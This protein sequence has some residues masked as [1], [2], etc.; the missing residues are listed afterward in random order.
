MTDRA[1]EWRDF[2]GSQPYPF[3]LTMVEYRNDTDAEVSFLSALLGQAPDPVL[4]IAC[5]RGR[6]AAR[7]AANGRD[8]VGVDYGQL[9]CRFAAD[10]Q[11]SIRVVSG[12]AAQLPFRDEVFGA[13]FCVYSSIGYEPQH[14]LSIFREA[15]R[16]LVP[17]GLFI[18]DVANSQ[19]VPRTRR[20]EIERVP[21]GLALVSTRFDKSSKELVRTYRVISRALVRRYRLRMTVYSSQ[22][23]I[24]MCQRN[25]LDV[26]KGVYGDFSGQPYDSAQSQRILIVVQKPAHS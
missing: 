19:C 5:G 8:V 1:R 13:A 18:L 2:F 4:D 22:A 11:P 25:G 14:D 20:L 7:L 23:L 12:N 24:S 26:V 17:G 6:H 21:G 3:D 9:N 15:A 10:R 16:V